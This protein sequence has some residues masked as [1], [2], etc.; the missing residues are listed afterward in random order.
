MQEVWFP[1]K[2][3]DGRMGSGKAPGS[4]RK[5]VTYV[6]MTPQA[7]ANPILTED[8]GLI[9]RALGPTERFRGAV[10][11]VTGCGGFLG[12][13]LLQF[14]LRHGEG[15]G[16]SRVIGLDSFLL[17]RPAWLDRLQREF[18]RLLA[19]TPFDV[20]RD[21]IE[22]VDGAG[23]ARFVLHMA[24][25]ASPSFYRRYPLETIDANVWGLRRLL[26]FYRGSE[27]LEGFL[28]FSS[29]EIYGD[30]PPEHV[31]TTE[32]YRG[33]V[34][35]LG[36]RACYDEAKRFGETLCSVFARTDKLPIAIARP[37]NNYGPGMATT[38]RRLPADLARAVLEDRD[39]VLHSDGSPTRSFCYAADAMA[40]YLKCLLHRGFDCFNIGSDGPE[41]SVAE[42]A[43]LFRAAGA[44]VFGY[45][46]KVRFEP[47]TD[48]DYLADNPTRR[49]PA[50][51]KARRLLGYAPSV[52][53]A[54][55]VV[56]YLRFLKLE[57]TRT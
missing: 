57:R 33:N 5:L 45:R 36:P 34:S 54:D 47:S 11:M 16:L 50:I 26:E 52:A 42:L 21:S 38:D 19:L 28:F 7:M 20:A 3:L 44:E 39:I 53:V 30:P 35:P 14:L 32:D 9:R 23:E 56:R 18:P 13:T 2:R 10:V 15:L 41:T 6:G 1:A 55:G 24:S 25:I 49:R 12:F 8:L 29:S 48:A 43:Q 37:F 4:P 17:G 27:R 46:G 22:S 40:G 31:P 51:D